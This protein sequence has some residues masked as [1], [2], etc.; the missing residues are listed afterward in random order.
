M[1]VVEF[2][3]FTLNGI[4]FGMIYAA[5]ALSLV[6]IWRGTRLVNFAQGAMAMLTTYIAI[7]V[8]YKTHSYWAGFV[9]ALVAG[10]A[11][12]AA[13]ELTVVRPTKGKPELNA[14]IVTIGLLI[15]FEGLA[16]MLFGGQFRSFPTGFSVTGLKVGGTALGINRFDVFTVAAVLLTTLILAVVF[17]YT[18]AGLRMRA[19][20]LNATIARLSGIR[21]ARVL[22]VG[23]ALA[24]LL[25]ALAGVLVSPS[26]FLYP[27]SMDAIF[28]LGFT[29]AVIGG[30]DS[31]VGAIVGGLILGVALNYVG[32]YLGSNLVPIFGLIALVAVLMIR[33]SGLF[34]VSHG[35]QV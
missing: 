10:L 5:I 29:A 21:V 4:V 11:L 12:G 25:G 15:F 23:W 1:P 22:T 9:I 17:R 26:T 27:N 34:S 20:A 24:G 13:S 28:V 32:G 3:Q 7:E 2:L 19:A 35:R 18:T 33:P 30:L 6:L 31:P 8:I 14:V 16:G